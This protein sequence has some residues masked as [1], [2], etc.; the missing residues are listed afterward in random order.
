MHNFLKKSLVAGAV[1]ASVAAHSATI[2]GSKSTPSPAK[3]TGS[4]V[5]VTHSFD[6]KYFNN[7]KI[8]CGATLTYSTGGVPENISIA[9][10]S[11][12]ITRIKSY[13][14]PGTFQATLSGN[15]HSGLVAC[16]G[17]QTTS[18]VV[19]DARPKATK[20]EAGLSPAQPG[21]T[22]QV[23]GAAAAGLGVAPK[24]PEGWMQYKYDAATGEL[25]CWAETTTCP[26]N[27]S[28]VFSDSQTGKK[29]CA[30]GQASCPK[31]WTGGMDQGKLTC[32]I[33]APAVKCPAGTTL[34]KEGWNVVGC[35]K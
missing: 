7:E 23:S 6:L 4:A 20:P 24:C 34:Y 16:L 28:L 14:S 30:P 31:G 35:K 12:V 19:E 13:S 5:Q 29:T 2:I 18:V 17:S 8:T 1:L 15:A 26:Q 3:L 10:P 32:E 33:V 27:W 11:M 9:Q 21:T 25:Q 22:T